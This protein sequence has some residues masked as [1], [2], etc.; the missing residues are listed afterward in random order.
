MGMKKRY[1]V[2]LTRDE[3][4]VL[5]QLVRNQRVSGNDTSVHG[6][7]ADPVIRDADNEAGDLL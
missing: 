1:I 2:N 5:T 6:V 7:N 3:R 4:E